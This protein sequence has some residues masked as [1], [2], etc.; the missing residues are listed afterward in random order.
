MKMQDRIYWKLYK[1]PYGT[2][3]DQIR[4]NGKQIMEDFDV[5]K[6][7]EDKKDKTAPKPSPKGQIEPEEDEPKKGLSA[8]KGLIPSK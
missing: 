8:L 1:I 7:Q 6:P 3:W 2:P 4:E 5:V